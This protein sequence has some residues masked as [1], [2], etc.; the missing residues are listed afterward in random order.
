[1]SAAK[2]SFGLAASNNWLLRG[3]KTNDFIFFT[4]N[5]NQ[6]VIFGC[7]NTS[8]IQLAI[9]SSGKVAIGKS[10]PSYSLDIAGDVNFD[11][12][13]RKSGLPYISSQWSNVGDTVFITDSNIAIGTSNATT[14]FTSAYDSTFHSNVTI[15]G[16]LTVNNVEYVTSNITIMNS[17]IVNSN[18]TTL[19]TLTFSNQTG[20]VFLD[21][22]NNNLGIETSAPQYKLDVVG[23][24]NTSGVFRQNGAQIIS[25]QWATN[26]CNVYV[27]SSSNIGIGT[28]NPQAQ[29]HVTSNVK[30]DGVLSV[31]SGVQCAALEFS[32][33]NLSA[34][35]LTTQPVHLFL[36]GTPT[37][38]TG[39]ANSTLVGTS[40]SQNTQT[41]ILLPSSTNIGWTPTYSSNCRLNIPYD[42]VYSISYSAGAPIGWQATFAISKNTDTPSYD[43]N[44]LSY[45]TIP[46]ITVGYAA[47]SI[48]AT[49]ALTTSD[50]LA[51]H[52]MNASSTA[53]NMTA[54]NTI[55]VTL[56]Y[57]T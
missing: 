32:T 4:G 7:S 36:Y 8:N 1:M 30:I 47:A 51:F 35:T 46:Y 15:F 19:N 45:G 9:N 53:L 17:Q 42:G 12:I 49:A 56:L 41:R 40:L 37:A 16:Q 33:T 11:G 44:T 31:A 3:T 39:T 50:Y 34:N 43:Q 14:G 54:N 23:D 27:L 57:R 5:S 55:S 22:L 18:I 21:S 48:T 25:S 6:S 52:Y 38:Y 29:L 13:L 26:S 2:G 10:N 20:S 28:S 24:V